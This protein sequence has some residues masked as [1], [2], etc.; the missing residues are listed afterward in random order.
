M[1]LKFLLSAA[2]VLMGIT[3][4]W[5]GGDVN[6]YYRDVDVKLNSPSSAQGLVYIYTSKIKKANN[7]TEQTATPSQTARLRANL[8]ASSSGSY[9]CTLFAY[10]AAGYAL[11]GFVK[12]SDYQAGRT[13][14]IYFLN[15]KNDFLV[16][17]A[18]VDTLTD[19]KADPTLISTYRFKA[20][21]EHEYYAVFRKAVSQTVTMRTPGNLENMVINS[22][23]GIDVDNL[24]VKGEINATDIEFLK[25][26]AKSHHLIRL[27]LSQ[28]KIAEI[29][30]YAFYNCTQLLEVKLPA[31]GLVRVGNSA[32]NGC[33]SLR[34]CTIPSYVQ[35]KGENIFN[36]CFSLNL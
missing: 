12:K 27:D 23:K 19:E 24:I 34:S 32:F 35:L 17:L 16:K 20:R 22:E 30:D 33:E 21:T 2:F 10:P 4:A 3:A 14:H 7:P 6:Y 13:S 36:G 18:P 29:P 31:S 15:D 11:D 25:K 9:E 26:M 1:K 5:A 28:A 8:S